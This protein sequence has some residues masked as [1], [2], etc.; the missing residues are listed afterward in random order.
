[1]T[2][3][4]RFRPPEWRWPI[5]VGL[6][7]RSTK[8][9]ASERSVIGQALRLEWTQWRWSRERLSVLDRLVRPVKDA[10]VVTGA[11]SRERA[12]V[13]KVFILESGRHRRTFWGWTKDEWLSLLRDAFKDRYRTRQDCRQ[14]VI[15]VMYLLGCGDVPRMI[16]R[17]EYVSVAA[18]VFGRRAVETSVRQVTDEL[19]KWGFSPRNFGKLQ[20]TLCEALLASRSPHL[21]NVT[22]DVLV[23]LRESRPSQS[24]ARGLK[25]ISRAL[26]AL[27]ITDQLIE[28]GQVLGHGGRHGDVTEGVAPEW[29]SFVRRW[30][31]T[32]TLQYV[33]RREIYYDILKAGRW[34][35]ETRP[36]EA[37]PEHWTRQTA[38]DWV[39]E[40]SRSV[41][42]QWTNGVRGHPRKG[43]PLLP[44]A[45]AGM[46]S[47]IK[48]FFQDLQEWEWIPRRFD[49][50][51]CFAIP[52]SM[53]SLI[54]PD[55]R[56][57]A[58]DIWAKLLWAG[59]NIGEEDFARTA[60]LP[61]FYPLSMIRALALVWLFAGLRGNEIMRLRVGCVR[62]NSIAQQEPGR[63]VCLLD[64]PVNKTSTAFT[65][66]VDRVVGE[67]IEQWERERPDQ[68]AAVD[69][70]TG[71]LV[72]YLFSYRTYRLAAD[73]LNRTL[74]PRLC[75]KAGVP[76]EDARGRITIHRARS[77][78][79]T[80]LFNAKEPMSLFELQEW[81]GHRSPAS[82]QHY[83]KITPTRLAKS[84]R[85]A[86][87]FDRNI[88]TVEVLID[89]DAV[90]SGSAANQPWLFYDLGHGFCTNDFF[91]QCP[92]RMACPKCAF[93][94]PK[95]AA[96]DAWRDGKA[97]LLRLRQS[98]PLREEEIAAIDDGVAAFEQLLAQLA[99]VPT[100]AGPTPAELHK[101]ELVQIQPSVNAV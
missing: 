15:A 2:L 92:H 48:R 68:P 72:H 67:A 56:V 74:I 88:R 61:S 95:P 77:T 99:E 28:P 17:T 71:E 36:G 30:R 49:P 34:A 7:D 11:R 58:D 101:N 86:G 19:R 80:Q 82:T 31:E 96:E 22:F 76:P 3:P 89:Q 81:L 83:A 26:M 42:G 29:I 44:R 46:L 13:L 20:A 4:A 21:E 62:W 100:P 73:F 57:I 59:L 39:A 35:T 32:S 69:Q 70:K 79:A 18:K 97:N 8:L 5:N 84:Y 53:K 33:T 43:K 64:I 37:S 38:I 93:Y 23:A 60:K 94:R 87:Y 12:N 63:T 9:T 25:L 98:I 54:G 52:R 66:P 65:K 51:I 41:V 16:G 10:L 50:S 75:K 47:S 14:H 40:V 91:D 78:I 85:D 45:R 27:G 90:K 24:C 55:P 1:M 6:Y